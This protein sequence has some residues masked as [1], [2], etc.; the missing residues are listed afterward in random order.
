MNCNPDKNGLPVRHFLLGSKWMDP[1]LVCHFDT[2]RH[3]SDLDLEVGRQT[4]NLKAS[5]RTYK[6]EGFAFCLLALAWLACP[7]LHWH[8]SLLLQNSS[9]YRRPVETHSLVGLSNYQILG[10]SDDS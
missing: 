3:V 7:F 4:F 6:K 1:L 5:V 8:W 2:E 9:V 10:L